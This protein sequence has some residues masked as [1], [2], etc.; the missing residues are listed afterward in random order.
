MKKSNQSIELI[1]PVGLERYIKAA[2]EV[3]ATYIPYDLKMVELE[4]DKVHDL[5]I[6]TDVKGI[7]FKFRNQLT[8]FRC[9]RS[10]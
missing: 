8:F 7:S 5:G 2:L 3:S 10:K 4:P 1:G 9:R 6:R